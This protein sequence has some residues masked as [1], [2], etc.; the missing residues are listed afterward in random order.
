M[1]KEGEIMLS[2]AMLSNTLRSNQIMLSEMLSN[3]RRG[4]Q[5]FHLPMTRLIDELEI[6][7]SRQRFYVDSSG[8]QH[9][10]DD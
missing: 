2:I 9:E 1:S 5:F 10:R 7:D 4:N 8:E 3:T 6:G